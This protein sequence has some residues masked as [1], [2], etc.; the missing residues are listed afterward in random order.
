MKK[1]LVYILLIFACAS[2]LNANNLKKAKDL[3]AK[4]E[5][6]KALPLFE[7]EYKKKPKDAVINH[8]Y[9]VC[10]FETGKIE[11]SESHLVYAHSRKV[12]EAPHYLAKICFLKYDF[13]G[14]IDMFAAYDAILEESNRER[15]PGAD[16]ELK[17]IKKVK[18]LF[19]HVE[20]IAVIDSILVDKESFFKYYNISS[21]SGT[22]N[23]TAIL[24]IK[25]AQ[26]TVVHCLQN[27]EKMLWAMPKRSDGK[28]HLCESV[29][30]IDGKWDKHQFIGAELGEGGDANYPYLMQDGIT[31]YYASNGK[32]SIGGYDIYMTR[33][34]SE[35]GEFLKPQNLGMP[36]NS[37][38][39]D[40][41]FVLDDMT[42]LGWWATDRNN[43]PDKITIYVFVRNE[44]R[45]NYN[46][47]EPNLATYAKLTDY[48]ATWHGKD[49]SSLI[50]KIRNIETDNMGVDD[51][52]VFCIKKGLIYTSFTDFKSQDASDKMHDLISLYVDFTNCKKSL[53]QIR[54]KYNNSSSEGKDELKMEILSLEGKLEELRTNIFIT[55]NLVRKFELK[56]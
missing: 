17:E 42:G 27:E 56:N 15:V 33:K 29:K 46:I 23:S 16:E 52:F 39:D 43:I 10:L 49:Y 51:H 55:E 21:E 41:M 18:S 28:M 19:E 7:K 35:T 5:Y 3:Y 53:K 30:L 11:E 4:G 1:V 37:D 50:S 36:Y 8:W 48:R 40:Y 9:G 26:N 12:I 24:P 20:K 34:D 22:L 25:V 2:P 45:E 14:A 31:L 6:S 32:N 54:E 47:N 38:A 13:Q 44:I